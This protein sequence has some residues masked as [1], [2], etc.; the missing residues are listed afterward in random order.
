MQ[1]DSE[2]ELSGHLEIT[3]EPKPLQVMVCCFAQLKGHPGPRPHIRVFAISTN[4]EHHSW[5]PHRE[6]TSCSD[7]EV[8]VEDETSK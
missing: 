5:K 2:D 4:W 8:E 6:S 1:V 7:S 3:D